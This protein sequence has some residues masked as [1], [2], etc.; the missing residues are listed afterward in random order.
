MLEA[1][2]AEVAEA[3]PESVESS[4][5]FVLHLDESAREEM[6]QRIQDILDEYEANDEER[7][8][9]GHPRLGG[10]FVLHRQADPG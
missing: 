2:T 9:S 4:S 6:M 5:R 7:S 10:L 1:F 3:G 8:N